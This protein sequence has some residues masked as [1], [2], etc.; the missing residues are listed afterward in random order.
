M[1]V[2]TTCGPFGSEMN[3]EWIT[4]WTMSWVKVLRD[5]A[6]REMEMSPSV[7]MPLERGMGTGSNALK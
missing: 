4:R 3:E 5:M 7:S 6:R 1:V 2:L